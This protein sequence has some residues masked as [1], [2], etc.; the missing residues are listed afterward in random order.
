MKRISILLLC[1]PFFS[2]LHAQT[3][4]KIDLSTEVSTKVDSLENLLI[5][6]SDDT[7]KVN[8][9]NAISFYLVNINPDKSLDYSIKALEL[10]EKLNYYRGL[11][12][13]YNRLG[14]LYR[15]KGDYSRA[16]DYCFRSLKLK[17][18]MDINLSTGKDQR[19]IAISYNSIGNIYIKQGKFLKALEFYYKALEIFEDRKDKRGI[20]VAYI[21]IATI[22]QKQTNYAK[23]LEYNFRCLKILSKLGNK[24]LMADTYNNIGGIYFEQDIDSLALKYFLKSLKLDEEI[25]DKQGMSI[26]YINVGLLYSQLEEYPKALDYHLKALKFQQEIDDQGGM[27]YTLSGIG[28]IYKNLGDLTLAIAYLDSCKELSFKVGVKESLLESY[29]LLST[30]YEE[31]NDF[32]KA[33]ELYNHYSNLKD[34]IFNEQ[35]ATSMQEMQTKYESDKKEKE[36]ELLTKEKEIQDLE[37]NRQKVFRNSVIAGLM[38]ALA[39]AF[40]VYNR[41]RIKQKANENLSE[42]YTK[43]KELENFKESM[44]GMIVHDLKNPLN[45]II[46]FAR[47]LPDK[48]RL[49]IISQSGK[50]MLNM[51][52]NILDVQKFE[53][54]E[55]KLDLSSN[56]VNSVVEDALKQVEVLIKHHDL[57]VY[58]RIEHSLEGK[59][60]FEIISRV[61]VN[62]LTNAIKYSPIGGSITLD[63]EPGEKHIKIYVKDTGAGI[64]TDKLERV[65]DKFSQVEAKRSGQARSTGL[66]L[67]F[68]KMVIE[69]HGGKIWAV[70]ANRSDESACRTGRSE[71]GKGTTFCF[72]LLATKEK[73]LSNKKE[74]MKV[75]EEMRKQ[76]VHKLTTNEIA[77]LQPFINDFK[78]IDVYDATKNME[79]LNSIELHDNKSLVQW[80][81]E[82][83]NAVY[84]CDEEKYNN[85]LD[86][87]A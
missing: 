63:A 21:N 1:L 75:K 64:P 14:I 7:G 46:G 28:K 69:A 48:S 41:Y 19:S 45:T 80:K 11:V 13:V 35:S 44:T 84:N 78:V 25:A 67:T 58:N 57:V 15:N 12:T 30:I 74:K 71:V 81:E 43:L 66:G 40:L 42:A 38:L 83:E 54:A 52:L 61:L 32:H 60:D 4:H 27:T 29:I 3:Q 50:Q 34:S 5:S 20:T 22:Y 39:L 55:V 26:S 76:D 73:E 18:N 17:E 85:L 6:S 77:F 16:L 53:D 37:L 23:A 24:G 72:T 65:F 33:F 8:L 9:L 36:I 82:M 68:C 47:Q 10:S 49:D 31:M 62:L 2:L 70:S 86:L 79:I 59:F 87:I 56:S 51:V